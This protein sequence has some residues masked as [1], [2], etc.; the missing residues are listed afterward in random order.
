MAQPPH[1]SGQTAGKDAGGDKT[2]RGRYTMKKL[3]LIAVAMLLA[4]G[5][6]AADAT[7]NLELTVEN[8]VAIAS[9]GNVG[10]I[11]VAGNDTGDEDVTFTTD[12]NCAYTLG[13]ALS[14]STNT[15]LFT[16]VS[17]TGNTG[18]GVAH[19]N[20]TATATVTWDST[21]LVNVTAGTYNVDVTVTITAS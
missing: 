12:A 3:I 14:N 1:V 18:A 6:F 21:D 10:P 16:G 17:M 9:D 8:Y 19:E 13:A 2:Q 20:G 5:A 7:A 11:S 4:A 15:T